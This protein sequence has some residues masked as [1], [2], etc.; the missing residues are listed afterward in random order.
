MCESKKL[1]EAAPNLAER[2]QFARH[3][4]VLKV[5]KALIV[6]VRHRQRL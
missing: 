2:V 6:R 4:L 1:E 3:I 5:V